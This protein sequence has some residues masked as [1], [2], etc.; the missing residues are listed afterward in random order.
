LVM[1]LYFVFRSEDEDSQ[2][3]FWGSVGAVESLDDY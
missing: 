2:T 3:Q 1:M